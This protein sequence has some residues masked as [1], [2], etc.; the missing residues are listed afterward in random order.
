MMNELEV[1]LPG[2]SANQAQPVVRLF[3]LTQKIDAHLSLCPPWTLEA[4]L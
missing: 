2:Q 4:I 3:S 1:V